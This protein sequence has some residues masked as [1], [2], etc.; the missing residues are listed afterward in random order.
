MKNFLRNGSKLLIRRQT[1]ILSA[2]FVI[3]VMIALSRVLGLVRN[4]VLAH[5][6]SAEQLAVYFAAFRLPEMIFEVLVFGALSSAF[7]PIFTGYL[8][9]KQKK[10]AW[11]VA[12]I[13]LNFAFL[14]F[15]CLAVVIFFLARPLY[16][17]IAPGFNPSQLDLAANLTRLLLLAQAFFVLSYFLTGVLES[18][19]RFLV[20]A[21]A[22]LFYNLGIILGAWFGA[23]RF[24]LYGPVIGA[25]VGAFCHFLV[26]LPVV[27]HLGFRPKLTLDFSHPGVREIGRLALPRVIELSFLQVSKSV[28]LFLAS[29]VSTAAY[30]YFT[31]ASSLQLLP[32]GFFGVSIAKAALPTLAHYSSRKKLKRFRQTFIA[33][34]N[35]IVFLVIPCSVFLA[36]L[37]VPLVRL[38]FGASRFSWQ[39][40]LETGYT[41]SAFCLGIFA[42]ALIYLLNRAFY[43]LHETKT[44]VKVSILAAFV[45]I[46]LG[47]VFIL[48]LKWLIWSLALAFSLASILQAIVLLFLLHRRLGR[49]KMKNISIPFMKVTLASLISGGLMFFFL[50]VLDRSVWDKELSFLGRLGLAL[51]TTF[52]FFILDTRYTLNL[53]FLTS[54]VSLLG[55]ASYLILAWAFKIKELTILGKALIRLRSLRTAPAKILKE[56]EPITLD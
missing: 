46:G 2:A 10:Q 9:Q 42:Q 23:E 54:L 17:L 20:P 6:F 14:F 48:G 44:P 8:S 30:T 33:S 22:P 27:I 5:F 3:M 47:I 26:Q 15:S 29:L 37:R 39:S 51:P 56:K 43:A 31:F 4:R 36:V 35:Q 40:T 12:A 7:I 16:Q 21:I 38:V 34:F 13:S 25:V 49:F 32:I 45:N 24:G 53:V 11:Q 52:E 18:L 41:L 55:I 1:T 28:E 50:K 19:Q